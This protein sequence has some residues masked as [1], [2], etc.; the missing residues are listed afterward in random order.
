MGRKSKQRN[1]NNS[2]KYSSLAEIFRKTS[3]ISGP[4]QNNHTIK[5]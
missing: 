1:I 5:K 4:V 2:V 3:D